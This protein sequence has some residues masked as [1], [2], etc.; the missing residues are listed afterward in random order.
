MGIPERLAERGFVMLS[1]PVAQ[2][3]R[4]T[5]FLRHIGM[6]AARRTVAGMLEALVP[7]WV[8]D[9]HERG[10]ISTSMSP[11]SPYLCLG[12]LGIVI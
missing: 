11:V 5:D 6:Y 7:G 1:A 8:H 3:V 4:Y 12:F 10:V 9:H 2:W